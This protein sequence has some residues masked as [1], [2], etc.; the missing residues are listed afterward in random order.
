MTCPTILATKCFKSEMGK[1]YS[2]G[3]QLKT[4][5]DNKDSFEDLCKAAGGDPCEISCC[6]DKDFCNGG[7]AFV[8]SVL[9]MVACALMTFFR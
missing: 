1:Q 6:D 7:T 5:C 4:I 3:C 8:V 9:L 2:K